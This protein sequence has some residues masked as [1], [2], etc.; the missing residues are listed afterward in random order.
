MSSTLEPSYERFSTFINNDELAV[1][2]KGI[3]IYH[4][5]I[6]MMQIALY[7]LA[8]LSCKYRLK[9][10]EEGFYH[11]DLSLINHPCYLGY[12]GEVGYVYRHVHGVTYSVH[13]HVH[14]IML[15]SFSSRLMS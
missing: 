6:V 12:K 8:I 5:L 15:T 7:L 4:A 14:D 3:A 13:R 9:I 11:R 1:L 10:H 2:S